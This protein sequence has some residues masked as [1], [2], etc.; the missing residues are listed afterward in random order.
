LKIRDDT[1][2]HTSTRRRSHSVHRR[3]TRTATVKKQIAV[4]SRTKTRSQYI[5]SYLRLDADERDL[6]IKTQNIYNERLRL[7]QD[8]L[9]TLIF[10]QAL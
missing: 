3:L 7:R 5:M 6:F 9:E 2:N 1:H 4:Q 8:A 10:T